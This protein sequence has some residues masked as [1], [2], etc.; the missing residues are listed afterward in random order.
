[1]AAKTCGEAPPPSSKIVTDE[2]VDGANVYAIAIAAIAAK[3]TNVKQNIVAR[4]PRRG[5]AWLGTSGTSA[6]T[7]AGFDE[8]RT[9]RFALSASAMRDQARR[10]LRARAMRIPRALER[11]VV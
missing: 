11:F 8:M 1:V 10:A 4:M 7:A 3:F 9:P 5:G 2:E 6:V